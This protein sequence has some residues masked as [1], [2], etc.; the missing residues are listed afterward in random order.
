MQWQSVI[1]YFVLCEKSNQQIATKLA[2]RD[3][4]DVLCLR[5]VHKWAAGFCA[6]HND[7]EEDERSERPA[8]TDLCTVILRFLGGARTLRFEMLTKPFSL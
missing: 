7:V 1:R 3:G 5:A 8:Q 4:E 6:G 2:K